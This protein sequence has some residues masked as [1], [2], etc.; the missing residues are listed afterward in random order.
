[1]T[2]QL[3]TKLLTCVPLGRAFHIPTIRPAATVVGG[4]ETC[5]LWLGGLQT[6]LSL[7]VLAQ[8]TVWKQ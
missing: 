7:H 6:S 1:M 8:L 3:A 4:Q 2:Y 5:H